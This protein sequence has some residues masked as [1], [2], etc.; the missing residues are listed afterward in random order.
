MTDSI[1]AEAALVLEEVRFAKMKEVTGSALD[2]A[3][4]A[5]NIALG[6]IGIMALWLGIMKV[7]EEAGLIKI[8]SKALRPLTKL[9]FP[10]IPSDHPAMGAMIMNI[11]ANMLGLS[12][13]AT[14]FGLKAME[15]LMRKMLSK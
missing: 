2:Y 15:E 1:S 3:G 4:N 10:R 8:I 14:P 6:L 11:S 5:V 7:A 9:L 13:A 12:N